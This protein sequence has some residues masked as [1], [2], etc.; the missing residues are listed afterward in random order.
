MPNHNLKAHNKMK[1]GL[2]SEEGHV[3]Q[4]VSEVLLYVCFSLPFILW[5][6]LFSAVQRSEYL[7]IHL[8]RTLCQTRGI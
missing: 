5:V 8:T 3:A 6:K 7:F 1:S 4:N 2:Q